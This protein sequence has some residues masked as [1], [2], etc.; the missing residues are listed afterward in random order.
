MRRHELAGKTF[1]RLKVHEYIGESKWR[2]T[3]E[4]GNEAL[5]CASNLVHGL[6][7]SCGCYNL[8]LRRER[9]RTNTLT[10]GE[11]VGHV[12]SPEYNAW[13]AMW[14]RCTNPRRREFRDYGAR[15]IRVCDRWKDFEN[16]LDDMGR[17]PSGKGAGGRALY[18]VDRLD[19]DGDYS[20]D[21]CRWATVLE[22]ARNKRSNR[23]VVVRGE[24]VLLTTAL[25]EHS[26]ITQT[27][28]YGRVARGMTEE[29][30]VLTP[31]MKSGRRA[32]VRYKKHR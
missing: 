3:C 26:G 20:P 17:R 13:R 10:H 18:S 7:R 27:Q 8:E 21:N 23:Y 4:C 1:G 16:F 32:G 29:D 31:R 28:F 30:A 11:S 12:T 15:G 19:N 6:T 2:T 9:A 24:R 14:Q 5:V 25:R 22:Q